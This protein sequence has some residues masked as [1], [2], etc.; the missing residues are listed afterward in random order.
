MN[1]KERMKLDLV[2]LIIWP[3]IASLL[4]L[5]LRPN[6][7]I[8]ILL[9]FGLPAVYLSFLAKKHIKKSLIFSLVIGI[10]FTIIIDYI[11]NLTKTWDAP[12]LFGFKI[13]NHIIIEDLIWGIVWV[14]FILIFY[15]YFLDQHVTKKNY[16]KNLKYLI[17]FLLILSVLFF[18]FL[19]INPLLLHIPYFY[20]VMGILVILLPLIFVLFEFPVLL[21]KF[22]KT[23]AYFFFLSFAYEITALKLGWWDFPGTEFIGWVEFL[24]LRFPFEELFFWIILG[25]MAVLAWY[26]FFDDDRK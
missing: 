7:L 17:I 2:L 24:G 11:A 22:L 6:N 9:F 25:A 26:E 14:Y 18:F 4:S 1:K 23:G 19:I 8:S 20:L 16:N 15:E 3:I 5:L 12:T 10:P 13:F 21:T